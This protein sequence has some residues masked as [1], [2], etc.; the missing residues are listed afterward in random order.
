LWAN[1]GRDIPGSALPYHGGLTTEERTGHQ[2]AFMQDQVRVIFATNAF[3]L[4]VDKPNIRGVL[5]WDIPG[6]LEALVQEQGR[7]GRD[8]LDSQCVMFWNSK[9]MDTAKWLIVTSY[10]FRYII[11][12]VF[13]AIKRLANAEGVVQLTAEDIANALN[14]NSKI[15][16]SAVGILT[17]ARVFERSKDTTNPMKVK[18]LKE[19]PDPQFNSVLEIFKTG[20][21]TPS[22]YYTGTLD[23]FAET[24]KVKSSTLM[25]KV[26]QLAKEGYLD[27]TLPFKGKTTRI[28]GTPDLVPFDRI[29][30]RRQAQLDKLDTVQEFVHVNDATKHDYLQQYFGIKAKET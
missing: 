25:T 5:H 14:I 30:E 19:H 8:G 28:V 20:D 22:G 9:S 15:V 1:L 12:R 26:R 2:N 11:E 24:A 23:Y 21:L 18:P 16:S 4:G 10:R 27:Y 17:A 3:G 29:Q 7:A 13:Y 6:S